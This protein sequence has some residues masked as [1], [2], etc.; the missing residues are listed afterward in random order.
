M[1]DAFG[2]KLN[3]GDWVVHAYAPP[4]KFIKGNVIG[5]TKKRVRI[6]G[7]SSISKT[8]VM[9]SLVSPHTLVK[10]EEHV[11]NDTGE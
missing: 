3:L 9:T 11:T 2:Q 6:A 4:V 5:I 1:E 7:Y 8:S 10:V